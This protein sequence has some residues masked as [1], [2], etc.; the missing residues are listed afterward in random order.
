M[1]LIKSFGIQNL[2][3]PRGWLEE[4]R[5][6]L[7]ETEPLEGDLVYSTTVY[8]DDSCIVERSRSPS[9]RGLAA[10]GSDVHKEQSL[11]SANS[12][13]SSLQFFVSS[14]EFVSAA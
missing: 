12:V 7:R 10:V 4:R 6:R 9:N 11:M 14:E 1:Q 5:T 2:G 13:Y 8:W 3:K